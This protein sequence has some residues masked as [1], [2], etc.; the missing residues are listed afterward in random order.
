MATEFKNYINGEWVPSSDGKTFEQRNPANMDEVTGLWPK[1]PREDAVK[2]IEAA[3]TAFPA[4]R[5][6]TVYQRAE[7]LFKALEAMKRRADEIAAVVTLEN[8]KSLAESKT[9]VMAAVKEMEFQINEGLRLGGKIM[10]S[11][12]PGVMA[13]QVRVPL[14]VCSVISPWNFPFNVPGRKC[15]PA[16]MAGNTV[17]F[18]PASLTPQ[19]GLEFVKLFEEAGLPAGVLNFING[20]GATVGEEMTTNPLVKAISF[21]GSTGVGIGIQEKAAKILART[22]LELGGKNPLVVLED[23]DLEAASQSAVTAAFACAGQWCTSTSR[24]VVHKDVASELISKIVE[25][26]STLKVGPG[27][28]PDNTMGPVCGSSQLKGIL[29]YIEIGKQEGAKLT[30][31]GHQLTDGQLGKG[32]FIA[33][34]IFTGV[35][36]QMRIAQEEIFGPVLS[37]I[38]VDSF[39][40]AM[41]VANGVEFGLSSSIYTKDLNRAMRFLNETD[42]GL[43]HVN[44]IS[45]FKEPQLSFGGVKNS[46]FG[47]PE[48]GETGIEFFT[49]H[50]VAYVKY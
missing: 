19:V 8:G 11:A 16:L 33:P 39:E 50:K 1:S 6:L 23:A 49:E 14:G 10:P 18:K 4:W 22:Q 9:E 37:I 35:T 44:I 34:T 28:D 40:E 2:A 43:T 32:C 12:M 30:L 21:T 24:V 41:E 17:V 27:T 5:A 3:Q 42:V 46:G 25:K 26:A 20:G 15:T 29:E 36:P 31:G 45:A 47:I 38:S 13:Y 48:A 7:Y